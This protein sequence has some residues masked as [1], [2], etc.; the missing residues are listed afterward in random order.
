MLPSCVQPSMNPHSVHDKMPTLRVTGGVPPDL[1]LPIF[2]D[3]P[4]PT[5]EVVLFSLAA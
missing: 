3:L 2:P 4:F 1:N 5:P